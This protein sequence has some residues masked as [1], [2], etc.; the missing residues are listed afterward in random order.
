MAMLTPILTDVRTRI[1]QQM[2]AIAHA[3]HPFLARPWPAVGVLLIVPGIFTIDSLAPH[4]SIVHAAGLNLDI[5]YAPT[6]HL[7]RPATL[8]LS[9]M[10]VFG[11]RGHFSLRIGKKLKENFSIASISPKPLTSNTDGDESVYTFTGGGKDAVEITLVPNTIGRTA[12]TIQYGLDPPV[13][14]SITTAP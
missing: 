8:T 1:E 13:P 3:R 4:A 2:R 12:A 14:F 7:N 9:T 10:S 6:A 5:A 11:A